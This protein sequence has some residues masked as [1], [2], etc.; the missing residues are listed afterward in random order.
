MR[1]FNL[2]ERFNVVCNSEAT[3]NGFRH[4]AVLHSNG[5]EVCRTKICY[6]NRTWECYEFESI[7][8]KLIGERFKGEEKEKFLKVIKTF[9]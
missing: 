9:S 4:V 8:E 6:L 5:F 7:L 3:R 1:I 2:D